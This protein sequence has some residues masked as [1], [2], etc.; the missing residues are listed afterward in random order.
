MSPSLAFSGDFPYHSF[1][2][3]AKYKAN[4]VAWEGELSA[5]FVIKLKKCNV[6]AVF[7]EF[8]SIFVPSDLFPHQHIVSKYSWDRFVKFIHLSISNPVYVSSSIIYGVTTTHGI[9]SLSQ[10]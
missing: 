9:C 1:H 8:C 10:Q 3:N 5:I 7:G 4:S 2:T 6:F